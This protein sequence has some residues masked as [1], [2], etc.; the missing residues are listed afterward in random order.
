MSTQLKVGD[1]A[2]DFELPGNHNTHI[3]LSQYL[4]KKNVILS[5][6]PLAFTG[7]CADQMRDLQ[8]HADQLHSLDT[9]ALGISVDSVPAKE[10][11]QKELHVTDVQF[12][13]DFEP[14]GAVAKKYGIYR[15]EGHSERAVFVVNKEGVLIFVNVYPIAQR[16][17]PRE[18]FDVLR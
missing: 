6:H 1:K 3:R 14:K 8:A 17:D 15:P 4:G 11:W 13:S 7:I 10:A 12:L 18:F 5:F 9:V 16:P 2:P